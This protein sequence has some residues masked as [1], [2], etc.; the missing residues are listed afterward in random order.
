MVEAVRIAVLTPADAEYEE[1]V[2]GIQAVRNEVLNGPSGWSTPEGL[3]PEDRMHSTI[4]VAAF[5]GT[6]VIGGLRLEARPTE[7][8]PNQ[9][10]IRKNVVRADFQGMGVGSQLL[11]AAEA[12]ARE[13]GISPIVLHSMPGKVEWYKK[14]GYHSTGGVEVWDNIEYP[15]MIKEEV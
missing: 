15:E 8:F 14:R 2:A 11:S 9:Y 4:N 1:A 12:Y 3:T 10:E 5:A 6:V 7:S 13:H